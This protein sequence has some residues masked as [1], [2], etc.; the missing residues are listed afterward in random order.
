M[1]GS[2]L[3]LGDGIYLYVSAIPGQWEANWVQIPAVTLTCCV[4]LGECLNF[5]GSGFSSL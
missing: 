5:S 4:T 1:I 3:N 2:R